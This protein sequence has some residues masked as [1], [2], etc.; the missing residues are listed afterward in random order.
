MPWLIAA[1]LI[2]NFLRGFALH[3]DPYALGQYFYTYEG[4]FLIRG[5]MGS[6]VTALA[7]PEPMAMHGLILVLSVIEY[8]GL[9]AVLLWVFKQLRNAPEPARTTDNLLFLILLSG[10]FLVGIG[11]TRGFHDALILSLGLLAWLA[12]TRARPLLAWVL[13]ALATLIHE[14]I[15]FFILPAMGWWLWI[16]PQRRGLAIPGTAGLSLA[17][18]AV[19]TIPVVHFGKASPEQLEIIQH[20][21][22]IALRTPYLE[23]WGNP[24]YIGIA[25]ANDVIENLSL[26]NYARL[27]YPGHLLM[28]G[29]ALAFWLLAA[30]PLIANRRWADMAMLS[31]AMLLPHSLYL[32]AEDVHRYLPYSGLTAFLI[33]LHSLRRF[34]LSEPSPDWLKPAIL[35]LILAQTAIWDYDPVHYNARNSTPLLELI[36]SVGDP[37]RV[38]PSLVWTPHA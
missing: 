20:K 11:A 13:M 29:P 16:H 36:R 19:L 8:L 22:E 32:F 15:V 30:G 7:G 27:R 12:W 2:W 37:D 9:I 38:R 14:Q 21:I 4:G 17:A 5:L 35:M 34:P 24:Q 28:L 3:P 26:H 6:V 33:A 18:M 31:L 23:V 25:A 10:P 1:L